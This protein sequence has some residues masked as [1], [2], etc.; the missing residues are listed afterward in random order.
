MTAKP[1]SAQNSV[2]RTAIFIYF[3]LTVIDPTKGP[4]LVF[5]NVFIKSYFSFI[6]TSCKEEKLRNIKERNFVHSVKYEFKVSLA[7]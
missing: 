6:M 1:K 7:L 5:L 2:M 3:Q 4:V